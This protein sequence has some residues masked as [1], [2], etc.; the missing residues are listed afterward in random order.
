MILGAGLDTFAF[1]SGLAAR[2][3]VF[4]VDHPAT[5]DWKRGRVAGSAE[6]AERPESTGGRRVTFV[7]V[8]FGRDSLR[9]HGFGLV[10][11][12]RQRDMVPAAAW[13]RSDSLRPADLSRIAHARS[14]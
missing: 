14:V 11:D 1:R 2:V 5:Q 10:R 6:G 3:R 8:D 4:E 12:V 13:E 7:P 9:G